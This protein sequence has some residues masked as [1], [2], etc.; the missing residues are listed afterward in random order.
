[1]A[2][3]EANRMSQDRVSQDR[4]NQDRVRGDGRQDARAGAAVGGVDS[5]DDMHDSAEE[6]KRYRSLAAPLELCRRIEDEFNRADGRAVAFR[7]AHR[8]MSH[9]A[10]LSATVA[11][12]TAIVA[13]SYYPIGLDSQPFAPKWLP[14]RHAMSL[15]ELCSAGV[16]IVVVIFGW[17]SHFKEKW[18]LWRH[19][20]ES[21]R[22]LR[23]R[24]LI[25]PAVWRGGAEGSRHWIETKLHEID[26]TTLAGAVREATPHG[27]FEG[28]Q[29]RL[30]RAVLRDLTEYYLS[31]RLNPQKEYL[32]N[33]T[34]SN[35]FSDWIRV[36]LPWFFFLSIVAVFLKFFVRSVPW[37]AFLALAAAMLPAAAAGVRTWRSAFEFSRNKGRF[38]AAHRAL[39]D[40][41]TRLVNE[42][43]SAVEA[44]PAGVPRPAG[45]GVNLGDERVPTKLPF[46]P[47]RGRTE[48]ETSPPS[49]GRAQPDD[50][51]TDAYAILRDLSWCEHILETE[52]REW[53]RLMYETEWFG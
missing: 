10:A 20:A 41:E 11:V 23:Y 14:S 45:R 43:F 38:E 51:D 26:R 34:Q 33:R 6:L 28:T 44:E 29:S 40:L 5:F 42:A 19:Q 25:H 52:H 50:E 32:A 22:L 21:Y 3:Q 30:P 47:L 31:R 18:L 35:E 15:I 9:G 36:Y 48:E 7:R 13:L 37:E 24:F 53:L 8:W 16:A 1:M 12:A 49:A 17:I 27:P 2:E 46:H 4:V 39:R